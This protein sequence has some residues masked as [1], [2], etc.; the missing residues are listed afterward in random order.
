MCV[1][2]FFTPYQ[3]FL[4]TAISAVLILITTDACLHDPSLQ[5]ILDPPLHESVLFVL[6]VILLAGKMY[7]FYSWIVES[8][9]E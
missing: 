3:S 6:K 9:H 2:S 5:E 8:V 1:L 7:I 4:I